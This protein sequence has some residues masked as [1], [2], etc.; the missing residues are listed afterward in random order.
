MS[1]YEGDYISNKERKKGKIPAGKVVVDGKRKDLY[2]GLGD[3]YR[4][5]ICGDNGSGKSN[6]LKY[7]LLNTIKTYDL[8]FTL[9]AF[10]DEYNDVKEHI[11]GLIVLKPGVNFSIN[12]FEPFDEDR[13]F[14][15][16]KYNGYLHYPKLIQMEIAVEKTLTKIA[17][18]RQLQ[19]WKD[20]YSELKNYCQ[21]QD[22][23][24]LHG[25]TTF[26]Q[27]FDIIEEKLFSLT[28]NKIFEGSSRLN[29][30]DLYKK[31]VIIDFSGFKNFGSD[32]VFFM[33]LILKDIFR[34]ACKNADSGCTPQHLT[35]IEDA[36]M[37][38]SQM[39]FDILDRIKISTYGEGIIL[40]SR[41]LKY[42]ND[43]EINYN[44]FS[45]FVLFRNHYVDARMILNISDIVTPK[46]SGE[47]QCY[48]MAYSLPHVGLLLEIPEVSPKLI[49]DI[50]H[51]KESFISSK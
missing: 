46:F 22:E 48:L 42:V 10:K 31:K 26:M 33:N 41:T 24:G 36:Q 1:Y 49:K 39:G 14:K 37:S 19:N 6:F 21:E 50:F 15:L 29:V 3:L 7:L 30:D 4:M 20:F 8:P 18:N 47:G 5:F 28:S 45:T 23:K 32:D 16:L 27:D 35:I 2:L 38:L 13:I 9:F 11:D 40:L 17:N 12:F 43:L 34:A 51:D 44:T 25:S